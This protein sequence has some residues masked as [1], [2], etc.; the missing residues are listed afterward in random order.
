[1]RIGPTDRASLLT[2]ELDLYILQLALLEYEVF[3]EK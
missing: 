3:H 2:Q 1:M